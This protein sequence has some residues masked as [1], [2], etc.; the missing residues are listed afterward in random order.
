MTTTRITHLIKLLIAIPITISIKQF[1]PTNHKPFPPCQSHLNRFAICNYKL[2]Y[3]SS[4][5]LNFSS[6]R[7][8]YIIIKWTALFGS[9]Y[10]CTSNS[11]LMAVL[12]RSPNNCSLFCMIDY[13]VNIEAHAITIARN[14]ICGF[15]AKKASVILC[16]LLASQ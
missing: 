16:K 5:A 6:L 15:E 14:W 9:G 7:L 1:L 13:I 3:T 8:T 4:A 2:N 12:S 10:V 11:S